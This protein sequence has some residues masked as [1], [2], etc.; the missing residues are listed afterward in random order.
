MRSGSFVQ[1]TAFQDNQQQWTELNDT[2]D[3]LGKMAADSQLQ[4]TG[5]EL[6]K[7]TL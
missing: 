3:E 1:P 5:F 2:G 4:L 7:M 6:S